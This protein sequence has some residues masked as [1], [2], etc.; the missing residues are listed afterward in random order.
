MWCMRS[1]TLEPIIHFLGVFNWHL[2]GWRRRV[3]KAQLVG[4]Q[5]GDELLGELDGTARL[6][7][8]CRKLVADQLAGSQWPMELVLLQIGAVGLDAAAGLATRPCPRRGDTTDER[9]PRKRYEALQLVSTLRWSTRS[10][11]RIDKYNRL[12]WLKLIILMV[13][14]TIIDGKRTRFEFRSSPLLS[15]LFI[16]SCGQH[17]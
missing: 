16:A 4:G 10:A 3:N 15:N 8:Q 12:V 17:F 14:G 7:P 2:F 9:L 13:C 1:A 5:E 11:V 6:G